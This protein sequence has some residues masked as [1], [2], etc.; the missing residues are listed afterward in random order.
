MTAQRASTAPFVHM[1]VRYAG[2]SDYVDKIGGI[3]REGLELGEPVMVAVP[4]RSMARLEAAL[5]STF[6]LVERHDMTLL[7][8]N[9]ACI[10]GGLRAFADRH[11][12]RR[13]RLVGEPIWA[14]RPADEVREAHRHEAL[15]NLAF[16]GHAATIVCPYDTEELPAEVLA[17]A[18]ATHPVLGGA[19][20]ARVAN[21]AYRP[22]HIDGYR[23]V[24][25]TPRPVEAPMLH[26]DSW[27]D[28][29]AVRRFVREQGARAGLPPERL[30]DLVLSANEAVTN[31]LRHADGRGEVSIWSDAS[32]V[33]CEVR[34][35]GSLGD[36][37]A[38]RV[39]PPEAATSGRGL[40]LI[41]HLC[42]L[43]E[44]GETTDGTVLR[45]HL[46]R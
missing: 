25:L 27:T 45:A 26:Y 14:G 37:L 13:C 38:G 10:M 28:V 46:T 35:H 24:A 4:P 3:V 12:Q 41:N 33:I 5:G 43:V 18:D 29:A 16:A 39:T 15:I 22:A 44:F 19:D 34:D 17:E 2:E 21:T 31:T 36:V 1:G 30:D 42:D 23:N 6:E 20:G 40:W 8:R 9:P 11:R 7:G 32:Q